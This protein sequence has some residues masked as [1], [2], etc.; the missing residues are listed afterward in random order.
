MQRNMDLVRMILL[1]LEANP[2]GC[3]PRDFGIKSYSPQGIGY[4]AHIMPQ[5]GV[6]EGTDTTNFESPGPEAVPTN[7]TWKGHGLLDL[8]RDQERW[9]QARAVIAK[10]GSAPVAVW[11]QVLTDLLMKRVEAVADK[12]SYASD[13]A[14]RSI[15]P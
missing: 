5:V 11:T 9:N 3:A 7:L 12:P 6:I 15:R 2:S 1:R 13:A 4:H 10:V 14:V 8:A